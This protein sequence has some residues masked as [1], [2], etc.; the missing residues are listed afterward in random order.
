MRIY[1]RVFHFSGES[2]AVYMSKRS[3]TISE[4][5][6]AV[7]RANHIR[8]GRSDPP[9]APMAEESTQQK[10]FGKPLETMGQ[11]SYGAKVEETPLRSPGCNFANH[12]KPWGCKVMGAKTGHLWPRKIREFG[13]WRE[14]GAR[15]QNK[16]PPSGGLERTLRLGPPRKPSNAGFARKRRRKGAQWMPAVRRAERSGLCVDEVMPARPPDS[17]RPK[18]AKKGFIL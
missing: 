17:L 1:S 2:R 7:Y 5:K 4:R 16:R 10:V 6:G 3:S 12:G 18:L 14:S 11:Q 9:R 8:Q 13:F 15:K